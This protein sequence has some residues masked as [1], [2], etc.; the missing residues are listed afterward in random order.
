VVKLLLQ[1]LVI[2]RLDNFNGRPKPLQMIQNVVVYLVFNQPK[3][4]HVKP[5]LTSPHWLIVVA[6]IKFKALPLAFRTTTGTTP[7]YLT[8]L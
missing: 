8:S 4:T 7:P 5:I 3:R 2:S 1:A 6:R